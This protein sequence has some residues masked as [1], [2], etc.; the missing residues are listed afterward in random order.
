MRVKSRGMVLICTYYFITFFLLIFF[1]GYLVIDIITG[2]QIHFCRCTT[3]IFYIYV[4]H[5]T[6]LSLINPFGDEYK[7]TGWLFGALGCLGITEAPGF[8]K[9]MITDE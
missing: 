2:H 4:V 3:I 1:N 9:D 8:L 6:S 5:F 7:I